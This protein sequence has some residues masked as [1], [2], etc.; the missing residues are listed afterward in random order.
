[1]NDLT[2]IEIFNKRVLQLATELKKIKKKKIHNYGAEIETPI[3]C[4]AATCSMDSHEK[5]YKSVHLLL[6]QRSLHRDLLAEAQ[7]LGT[8]T[9]VMAVC[10]D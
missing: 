1:M 8:Q 4:P 10:A 7:M 6:F 3:S 9:C 5:C 2:C